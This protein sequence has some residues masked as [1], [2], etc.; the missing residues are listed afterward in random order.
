MQKTMTGYHMRKFTYAL[1][2]LA[3]ILA[4]TPRQV[5]A[6]SGITLSFWDAYNSSTAIFIGRVVHIEAV[7]QDTLNVTFEVFRRWKGP[8]DKQVVVST[9]SQITACGIPFEGMETDEFLVYAYSSNNQLYTNV[10]SRTVPLSAAG[11]DFIK[12]NIVTHP[13]IATMVGVAT[14]WLVIS[15]GRRFLRK[16]RTR[17]LAKQQ[18]SEVLFH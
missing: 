1:V 11:P 5:F 6:C 4:L 15:I 14:V 10:F 16:R 8:A 2:L 18:V 7:S 9:A 12:L 3:I 17:S 13:L